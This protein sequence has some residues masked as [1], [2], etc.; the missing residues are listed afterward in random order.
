[1]KVTSVSKPARLRAG[2]LCRLGLAS[3]FAGIARRLLFAHL[4]KIERGLITIIEGCERHVF[5]SEGGLA[6]TIRVHDHA[7]YTDIAFGGS[8]GAGEAYMSGSWS[9]D[10]L[11]TAGQDNRDE[12]PRAHG[13]RRRTGS[14]RPA[15][16]LADARPAEEHPGGQQEEHLGPLRPWERLL[17]PMARPDHDL[18][19]QHFRARKLDDR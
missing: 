1:M 17:S 18:L 5:G 3:I 11:V 10:D 15:A 16:A 6:A 2:A 19:M 13:H 7:F 14:L 12:P 8:I 4:R 9:A